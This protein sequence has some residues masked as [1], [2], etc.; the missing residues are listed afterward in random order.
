MLADVVKV[1][2]KNKSLVVKS[3]TGEKKIDI[4]GADLAGYQSIAD[5]KAG[6]KIAVLYNE[7][8]GKAVAKAV[9]NHAAM[10]K[11][12]QPTK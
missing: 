8:N 4:S 12:T 11:S 7:K 6:D 10:M 2:Q 9:A 3:K 5:I 1:D